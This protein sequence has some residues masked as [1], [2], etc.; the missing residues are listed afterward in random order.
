MIERSLILMKPDAVSRGLVGEILTRF[1]K[2]GLK[3]VGMKMA[4]PDKDFYFHHY[5]TIGK[6][7]SRR[8]Q[9]VFDAQL[10]TM[11][12][13]PVIAVALE[14]VEAVTLIRK[15]VGATNSKEALPGTIRGDYSHMSFAY[16]DHIGE[17]LPNIIHASGDKDEADLEVA[18]WFKE[19]EL[20]DY[21]KAGSHFVY[22][23]KSK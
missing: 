15:M 3:I 13:G 11:N 10:E 1:E 9:K 16:A 8:G 2:V 23:R 4:M 22:G 20:F 14:G 17:G 18:H 7:V 12:M 19:N 5:E 21:D 6:V